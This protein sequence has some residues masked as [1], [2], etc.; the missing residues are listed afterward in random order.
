MGTFSLIKIDPQKADGSRGMFIDLK[1][2]KRISRASE[3]THGTCRTW[4]MAQARHAR[5]HRD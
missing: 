1:L 5:I 3:L 2:A 4:R